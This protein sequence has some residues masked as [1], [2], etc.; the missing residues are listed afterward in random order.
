MDD[1]FA[2][3]PGA[4]PPQQTPARAEHP[5]KAWASSGDDPEQRISKLLPGEVDG[6]SR[7]PFQVM[8]RDQYLEM[9]KPFGS[10]ARRTHDAPIALVNLSDLIG[11]QGTIN[12]ERLVAHLRDPAMN[13]GMRASGH[14]GLIDRPV[15][16]RL[17]GQLYLHDGHHRLTAAHL[18][19]QDVA[20]VRLVDL[21]PPA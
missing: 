12:R 3:A 17:G 13:E 11:I 6:T 9:I 20:K 2:E 7:H 21:D 15:V 4:T 5:A 1:L 8:D 18:R 14:G 16:V 10:I 19:G